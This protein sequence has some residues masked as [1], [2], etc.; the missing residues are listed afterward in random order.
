MHSLNGDIECIV[1][2][3]FTAS[4]LMSSVLDGHSLNGEAAR[5]LQIKDDKINLY[6]IGH[7]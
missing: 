5:P 3:K 1:C 7:S 2:W 6:V 4:M